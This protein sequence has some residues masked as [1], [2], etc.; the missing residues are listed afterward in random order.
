MNQEKLY[1]YMVY[2]TDIQTICL[3]FLRDTFK[4]WLTLPTEHLIDRGRKQVLFYS[5]YMPPSLGTPIQGPNFYSI[6]FSLW[7]L[8]HQLS[9]LT[10]F[11]PVPSVRSFQLDKKQKVPRVQSEESAHKVA[12]GEPWRGEPEPKW[13]ESTPAGADAVTTSHS[14]AMSPNSVCSDLGF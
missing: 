14:T 10:K 1:K 3:P 7:G 11:H 12:S 13:C 6:N 8:P 9:V 5:W 4:K 2:L